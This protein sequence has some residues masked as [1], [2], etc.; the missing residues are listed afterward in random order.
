MKRHGLFLVLI[1]F[2]GLVGCA[3]EPAAVTA[4]PVPAAPA[5]LSDAGVSEIDAYLE[6]A[7]ASGRVPKAVAIVAN[8]EGVIF[9]GAYG[10]Q[11]FGDDI[12]ASMGS[13]FNLASMTKPVTSV[14]VMM[15]AEEGAFELD[16]PVEVYLPQWADRQVVASIDEAAGT[17]ETIPAEGPITIRQLLSHT[18]GLAYNFSNQTAQTLIDVTGENNPIDLPLVAE[19]G[20]VW[21]YSGSTAV[22]GDLVA[23]VSG[24]GLDE[25]MET[26]LFEPLGMVDTAYVVPAEKRSRVV[27]THSLVNGQL[28]ENPVPD[29]V[30]SAV[31]GDGGLYGT[32]PDYI[33]FLQMLLNKGEFDGQRLLSEQSVDAMISNQIGGLVAET[34]VSTNPALSLDFPAPRSGK[35]GLGFLL[36]VSNDDNPDLRAPGSYTWAGIFNTHFW[37]DPDREIAGVLLMQQLPFYDTEAM[38][39]YQG[40]EERVNRNLER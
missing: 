15:L 31:R 6:S 14:A 16:D 36:T 10:K 13:L 29:T 12:D 19:P 23:A 7:V 17:V 27:S 28:N 34:Q 11:N 9:E 37:G 1:L 22:L 33:R 26:R 4:P 2:I 25:F 3:P 24:M 39:V 38:A 35:F 30:Q 20:T 32:A 5:V 18:S 40:F 21:Y 8:R